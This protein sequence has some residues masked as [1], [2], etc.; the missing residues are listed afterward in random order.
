MAEQPAPEGKVA[1]Q[2][3]VAAKLGERSRV[4]A[5]LQWALK[6]LFVSYPWSLDVPLLSYSC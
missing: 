6:H 1:L 4:L 5:M 3:A 2:T